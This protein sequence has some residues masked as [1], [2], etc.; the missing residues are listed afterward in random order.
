MNMPAFP[1]VLD[2]I[3]EVVEASVDA[4][5]LPCTSTRQHAAKLA[6]EAL[7]EAGPLIEGAA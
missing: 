5:G 1:T 3:R 2:A 6:V 7:R 4:H